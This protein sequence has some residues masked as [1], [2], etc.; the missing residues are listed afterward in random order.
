M[1]FNKGVTMG[2]RPLVNSRVILNRVLNLLRF[3]LAS[4][5]RFSRPWTRE[6]DHHLLALV[7]GI[8]KIQ[9]ENAMR[10]GAFLV[11]RHASVESGTFPVSYT[12]MNGLS[13]RYAAPR[14]VEDQKRIVRELCW[15]SDVLPRDPEAQELVREVLRDEE[16]H[17]KVLRE[18]LHHVHKMDQEN[19]SASFVRN[20]PVSDKSKS[21]RHGSVYG[22]L[23][24]LL[25]A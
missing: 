18:E 1:N 2:I 19:V 14:V 12:G 24:E 4:Y 23:E 16:R 7:F 3:S 5:L 6:A 22:V 21:G 13:I 25:H 8:A 9:K 11:E 15:C 20:R 17:L 10:V